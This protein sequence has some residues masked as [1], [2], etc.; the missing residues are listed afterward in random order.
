MKIR[1]LL[2]LFLLSLIACGG[3]SEQDPVDFVGKSVVQFAIF[4]AERDIIEDMAKAYE[5][6]NPDVKIRF[7]SLNDILGID[8]GDITNDAS[9][10]ERLQIAQSADVYHSMF[11]DGQ[12]RIVMTRDL[13]PFIEADDNF[14]A[15][16]FYS[17]AIEKAKV[18]GEVRIL[19][20]VLRFT[21][22]FYNKEIFDKAGVAYPEPGWS[23][24]DF[25]ATAQALT[26]RNGDQVE[27]WG[28]VDPN[29]SVNRYVA[30]LLTA[31]LIDSTTN[32]PTPRL[33]D[34]D[35]MAAL[36]QYINFR[37]NND[38]MPKFER[39]NHESKSYELIQGEKAAMWVN[40]T[41]NDLQSSAA[42]PL[43]SADGM[44]SR[45]EIEG[46]VM[47]AG[48]QNPQAAWNWMVFLSRQQIV[49]DSGVALVPARR[50]VA[51]TAKFWDT[52]N[53]T[54][55]E[56]LQ[57]SLDHSYYEGNI[58]TGALGDAAKDILFNGTDIE[59]ALAAAQISAEKAIAGEIAASKALPPIKVVGMG[60]AAEGVNPD[61]IEFTFTLGND[62][63][64]GMQA[65]ANQFSQLNPD[66]VVNLNGGNDFDPE[67][68]FSGLA[69]T[70]DC[71][72][73]GPE[74]KSAANRALI[75]PLD[76]LFDADSSIQLDDF[77]PS[78]RNQ[79]TEEGQLWAVPA[80]LTPSVIVYNRD[81]FDAKGVPYPQQDW[82]MDEFLGTAIQL[83]DGE[84]A[85]KV[86]GFVPG[87]DEIFDTM[88]WL[89]R[90]GST[91]LDDSVDPPTVNLTESAFA[92]NARW[93]ANLTT[94]AGVKPVFLNKMSLDLGV[95]FYEDR[96]ELISSGRAAMWTLAPGVF[97]GDADEDGGD[98]FEIDFETGVAAM[99]AGAKNA[100]SSLLPAQGYFI[101]AETPHRSHCWEW[102]K[103]LSAE[104][105]IAE[106]L[107]GRKSVANSAEYRE[108]VGPSYADAYLKAA[109]G[110]ESSNSLFRLVY[111]KEFWL[112]P[113]VFWFGNAMQE[114]YDGTQSVDQALDR[115]QVKIDEYHGC[116]AQGNGTNNT[117]AR[118]AC[119]TKVDASL[120][121][122]FVFE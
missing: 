19:P 100:A 87:A 42:V 59:V 78:M 51:E 33:Q 89:E 121:D 93:Y 21:Q 56:T 96:N 7:I 58:S 54:T 37:T 24:D 15:D 12:N 75:L 117:A 26:I 18:N 13:T 68:G 79:F 34:A 118:D 25:A 120:S 6:E 38:F 83:T 35:V 103:F 114:I 48:T 11:V 53:E 101:S 72:K 95:S 17:D 1:Y 73:A 82:T 57:F 104:V 84:G 32:P 23:W 16:D 109:E 97:G 44:S 27:Q 91:F 30:E 22:I 29:T 66:S 60:L 80:H 49:T 39:N 50:S 10:E 102:I 111:G 41:F 2:I 74:I 67:F 90:M 28:F 106:G 77:F 40:V 81:I 5:A 31:P 108:A 92:S 122:L 116:I 52:L 55:A 112:A 45:L 8:S 107:P 119:I 14:D 46:Y 98:G 85:D 94:Q 9:P 99:P 64:A 71:F 113:T 115:A 105:S 62:S 69:E 3:S 20:S 88:M 65:L 47:S 86:Y 36:E 70:S 110:S 43:H 4:D 61:A 63:S 76:A